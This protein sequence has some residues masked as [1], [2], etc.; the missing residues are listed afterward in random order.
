[1]EKSEEGINIIINETIKEK[2]NSKNINLRIYSID[3]NLTWVSYEQKILF[4]VNKQYMVLLEKLIHFYFKKIKYV[5][6]N[7]KINET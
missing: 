1:M 6:E 2:E 4:S 3:K 7:E 5:I